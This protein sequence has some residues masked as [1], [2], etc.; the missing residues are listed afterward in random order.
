MPSDEDQKT[1]DDAHW[2]KLFNKA[3]FT[4]DHLSQISKSL[5]TLLNIF[6]LEIRGDLSKIEPIVEDQEEI[7][8]RLKALEGAQ[9]RLEGIGKAIVVG[10]AIVAAIGALNLF[11]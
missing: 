8:S 1:L 2:Y 3:R 10:I 11:K 5:E 9:N 7:E 4:V 6:R